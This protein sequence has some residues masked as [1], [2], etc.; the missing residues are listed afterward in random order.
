MEMV[1]ICLFKCVYR[2]FNLT[3]TLFGAFTTHSTLS[4]SKTIIS[5]FVD[6]L[7]YYHATASLAK[8]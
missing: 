1:E 7:R 3:S 6:R 2:V 4:R 5:L 8:A